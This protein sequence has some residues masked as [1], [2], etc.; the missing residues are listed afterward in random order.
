LDNA[1]GD[2]TATSVAEIAK[3]DPRVRYHC[4]D[5]NLGQIENFAAGLHLVNTPFFSFLSDDDLLLPEFYE[6]A[7]RL[8]D[9]HPESSFVCC[10]V[11]HFTA[12]GE[13]RGCPMDPWPEGVYHPPEGLLAQLRYG[14]TGQTGML[15]RRQ[16][17]EKIGFLDLQTAF[18]S[19]LDFV[20][21]ASARTSFVMSRKP[22]AIY[23]I[24]SLTPHSNGTYPF[25][26]MWPAWPHMVRNLTNDP[27]LPNPVKQEVQLRLDRQFR[28][29][30][31][32]LVLRYLYQNKTE[33]AWKAQNILDKEFK[34]WFQAAVLRSAIAIHKRLGQERAF[35]LW[36][37]CLTMRRR[38]RS[39]RMTRAAR[40]ENQEK[41][42]K[43]APYATF[44]D[45]STYP[46]PNQ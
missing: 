20:Q 1:S 27:Q 10:G 26:K 8:F 21:R 45:V 34:C 36:S 29:Q 32:I 22:S 28:D 19:D 38:W 46:N 12:S 14:H 44:L 23:C 33:D 5:R 9:E 43:A 13:Y 41:A 31:F 7:M 25:D 11:L 18:V 4:H 16:I 3:Q 39:L 6:T 35:A 15:F 30:L 42:T 37:F 17:M 2:N 40:L 24:G